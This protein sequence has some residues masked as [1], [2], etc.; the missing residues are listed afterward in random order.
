MH[1]IISI[2]RR[3]NNHYTTRVSRLY[4]PAHMCL[5]PRLQFLAH[6]EEGGR[7][8]GMKVEESLIER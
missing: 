1:A 2:G 7:H 4:G 3:D 8:L 5:T 6:I